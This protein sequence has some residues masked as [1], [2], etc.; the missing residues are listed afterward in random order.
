[1]FVPSPRKPKP[2][3][4]PINHPPSLQSRHPPADA[5]W[6]GIVDAKDDL[7]EQKDGMLS[8]L[9]Q[10][11]ARQKALIERLK[12][13]VPS[14]INSRGPLAPVGRRV[15]P[16]APV[17]LCSD[18]SRIQ[19]Q[20]PPSR[21]HHRFPLVPLATGPQQCFRLYPHTRGFSLPPAPL[22]HP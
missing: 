9:Q 20:C 18:K 7:L 17:V 3:S 1:M 22:H 11:L 8:E 16:M 5:I 10:D 13:Y 21:V 14:S 6:S 2:Q 19:N 4:F 12:K 15:A